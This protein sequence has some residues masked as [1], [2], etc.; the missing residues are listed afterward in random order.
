MIPA[1]L[2]SKLTGGAPKRNRAVAWFTRWAIRCAAVAL[3]LGVANTTHA[4]LYFDWQNPPSGDRPDFIPSPFLSDSNA[5]AVDA[6]LASYKAAGRPLAV[7]INTTL[8]DNG[9]A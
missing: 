3:A 1:I 4:A 7:K 8:A 6:L 5:A 2:A 9:P